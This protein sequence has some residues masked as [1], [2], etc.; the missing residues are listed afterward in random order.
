MGIGGHMVDFCA[1]IAGHLGVF[2][3]REKPLQDVF[4]QWSVCRIL[5]W[6][7]AKKVI[8]ASLLHL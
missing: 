8:F 6:V 1:G 4:F 5:G 7:R 2:W 3:S